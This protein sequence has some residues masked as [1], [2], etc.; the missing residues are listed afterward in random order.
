MEALDT[1]L[2][3]VT[4]AKDR[5]EK[6]AEYGELEKDETLLQ[7]L[8]EAVCLL[9]CFGSS[10]EAEK[11][12]GLITLLK[13]YVAN[14]VTEKKANGVKADN[15]QT[16]EDS[17]VPQSI[18]PQIIAMACRAIGIG[19]ASWAS[20]APISEARNDI[21]AEAIRHLE[22]SISPELKDEFNCSSIYT[23]S[24]LLAENRD[25][26]RAI[27]YV[28]SALAEDRQPASDNR[29][30]LSRQRDL[31]PLW[32]LLA[33]LLSAKEEF[34]IAEQSCEAAFDQFPNALSAFTL[35]DEAAATQQLATSNEQYNSTG[36][37]NT[38]IDQLQD[39]EKERIIETRMTQLAF[40]ELL[41][42]PETALNHSDKLIGLFATLFPDLDK[43]T[44][45]DK[46]AMGSKKTQP[47]QRSPAGTMSKRSSIFGRR[48]KEGQEA[49][50]DS[51]RNGASPS[52][53]QSQSGAG[54]LGAAENTAQKH[55]NGEAASRVN[56]VN[57]DSQDQSDAAGASNG[58]KT[59]PENAKPPLPPVPDDVPGSCQS[60]EQDIRRPVS[61]RFY[62][63]TAVVIR[64]PDTQSRKSALGILIEI[65]LF[66][67]GLYRRASL[68]E[69]AQEACEEAVAQANRV[70]ALV[71]SKESSA[72]S[73]GSR[74]WAGRRSSEELRADIY[75]EQGF[76]SQAQ[77][78]PYE[79]ID[80]FEEALV[81]FPHHPKATIGLAN[82][83]LDIWDEKLSD[84]RAGSEPSLEL[85]F[86]PFLSDALKRDLDRD[87]L[88]AD[89]GTSGD[90][91]QE[92][93]GSP[94]V[95]AGD[96]EAKLLN[97]IAARERAYGLLSALTKLGSSWDD[98]DAWYTLGR[99][100]EAGGQL[101]K[102]R[103]VL[104]WC[105][106]LEDRRP[107]RHWSSIGSGLYV[108]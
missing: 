91:P 15:G 34:E 28:K 8:S 51:R 60:P 33:L 105:I 41:E 73:F 48:Q 7:T 61:Y 63:P 10:E 82:L 19:L 74:G 31:V 25:L 58:V 52:S 103:K 11:V 92:K 86:S 43:G 53:D 106:E 54:D 80:L 46:S 87:E 100:Y 5:A 3:I 40:V 20:W 98:S 24:V 101:E 107:V 64:F 47:T 32:H 79:A 76:L 37:R 99:V 4:G 84:E 14:H 78:R 1:Y 71:A 49:A 2:E 55:V 85:D 97:R 75:A 77:S 35:N 22:R 70:E 44:G 88:S 96:A 50:A 13:K 42:G 21:R 81:R 23:L 6:A 89:K 36:L 17:I 12:N 30:D 72:R 104:W 102:L 39:R 57:G 16:G 18:D 65:W 62:S 26:N 67:A 68:F 108:L 95:Q 56:G 27:G 38:L 66:L 90:H 45:K 94:T 29:A 9:S 69:D 83:Q 59:Q 93:S